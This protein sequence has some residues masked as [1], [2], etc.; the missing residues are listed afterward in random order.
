MENRPDKKPTVGLQRK[1]MACTYSTEQTREAAI[2]GDTS[3][4]C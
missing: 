4:A 3:R 1:Q 2:A